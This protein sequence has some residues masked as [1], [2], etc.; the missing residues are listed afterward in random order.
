MQTA[1]VGLVNADKDLWE[2][3]S[4]VQV[5]RTLQVSSCSICE[6]VIIFKR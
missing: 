2:T 3:D 6:N 5:N 1:L 4:P